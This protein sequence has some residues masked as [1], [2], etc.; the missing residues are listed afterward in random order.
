MVTQQKTTESN[1]QIQIRNLSKFYSNG[2]I[3]AVDDLSLT[4]KQGETFG[5]L[6]PNGAGKTSTLRLLNGL[7]KPTTGSANI[8]GYDILKDTQQVKSISGL[9]AESPGVYAK[10]SAYE[11][12]EFMGAL[13]KIPKSKLKQRINEL[14]AFFDLLKRKNDLIEGFS[15]GMR[16]KVLL[17]SAII[18]DPE[19][20]FL[21]EPTA[22]L[23]PRAARTVKQLVKN[24]SKR[25]KTILICSHRLP[26][27]EELC[28]RIGIIHNGQLIAIGTV[29]EIKD[30]SQTPTL[31]EAFIAITGGVPS[32]SSS[33]WRA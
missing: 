22:G 17:A 30:Q 8:N 23:D 13:Y 7:I 10:L 20:I 28:D 14:L 12:L 19:V 31:E 18:H 2:K 5:L 24:M 32:S 27:V 26:V 3:R 16:Q 1:G 25:G 29:S 4:I 6:G 15:T 9:L 21:D 11:F 33:S